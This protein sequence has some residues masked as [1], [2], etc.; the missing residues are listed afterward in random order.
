[1]KSL[2]GV[3]L[4]HVFGIPVLKSD[5]PPFDAILK[6]GWILSKY[7]CS[8]SGSVESNVVT[9]K[10]VQKTFWVFSAPIKS[11]SLDP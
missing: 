11:L 8:L 1:M 10:A 2:C 3:K 4:K 5:L 7:I 9:V 6:S